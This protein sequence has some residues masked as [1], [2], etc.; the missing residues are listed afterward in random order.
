MT[1]HKE[2][3]LYTVCQQCNTNCG[4]RVKV[5]QGRVVKIEGNPYNPW[6]KTP[7]LAYDTPLTEAAQQEGAL[8]PKGYAGMQTLYDPYRIKKVLKRVGKRGEGAWESIDFH[9]AIQEVVR[10][11][12]L[13]GEGHVQ[14][15]QDIAT[16][17]DAALMAALAKDAQAV[18]AKELSLEDFKQKHAAHLH[19]LI[20]PNHPDLGPKNNQ[21]CYMWGR[22]KGGRAEFAKR[23]FR[24]NLGS[25]NTHGHTTICQGSL[26][27]TCKAMSEQFHE[28]AFTGGEKFYWQADTQHASFI[29]FVGANPMEANY[30]PTLRAG[31]LV[32]QMAAG[33]QRIAVADPRYSKTA[34]KA[35]KWI[36]VQPHGVGALG[37]A[38]IRWIVEHEKYDATY[39]ANCTKGAA[40]H[41]GEPTWTQGA[42]LVKIRADGSPGPLLR[43]S[44]LGIATQERPK[45]QGKQG[46]TWKFDAFVTL[47]QG[48]PLC[49]D[50]NAVDD[51]VHGELFVD[52]FVQG[53]RV[54]SVLQIYKEACMEKSLQEWAEQAGT[55]EAE[56]Q[57]LAQEFTAHGKKAVADIH[58]GVSQHTNGFYN[59]AIWMMVNVLMG[60]CDWKGGMSKATTYDASG[61]KAG[62]PFCISEG[63]K[64]FPWGI[65]CI[66]HG[67]HY[68]KTTL[69]EGYPAKRVW[70]PFASDIYQEV[71]PS[72]ADGYPYPIKALFLYMAAPT[73]SLPAGHELIKILQDVSAIPL[74]VAS[75]IT[76]GESS[77]Y[78][79]YIFPDVTYLER[80]EF[81]GSHPSQVCKVAPVRQPVVA[82]LTD[83]VTVYGVPMSLTWETTLLAMAER[84][85]LSG[86]GAHAF[87]E[88]TPLYRQEDFYLRMVANIAHGEKADGTQ[89][90]P[91]ASDADIQSF[92]A[93]RAHLPSTIFDAQRWQHVVGAELWPHVVTVLSRGGRFQE[94]EDAYTGEYL[95]NAYGKMISIYFDTLAR[96]IHSMTGQA[97]VPYGRVMESPVDCLGRALPDV[98]AGYDLTLI[99][100]KTITQCKS[101]T[102]GNTWLRALEPENHV[103]LSASDA[104]RLGIQD[105]DAVHILSASNPKGLWHICARHTKPMVGKA[106]ILQGLRPGVVA[107]SLG[108]GHWANGAGDV[109]IDGQCVEGD[110]RR[111]SG[112]HANAAMRV[113]PVLQNT[114]LQDVVGGSVVFYQTA[115][116]VVKV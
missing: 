75:D 64:L 6:T 5:Q 13:F 108:Y 8:C 83:T 65:S 44:D 31:K 85:Q 23:F 88:N 3:Q 114:A 70:F 17:R 109:Y 53:H 60:N 41:D 87:G 62:G 100:Y 106:K 2:E 37:M 112:I 73:Y 16:L 79:D 68:E 66:R 38:M 63:K 33:K 29:L 18:A 48:K 14:G 26:Y 20:D 78:A 1:R 67:V 54:K 90:V 103:E 74:L 47:Y 32:Q 7:H 40:L 72:A 58:R 94:Y 77:M 21:I 11:G 93:A 51:V 98:A 92:V 111:A 56:I 89:K 55:T 105:G 107:F 25:V 49:F 39:L 35:W 9:Q 42:W 115:V 61:Q 43:A 46:D 22:Q 71:L 30:G 19:H 91:P 69:F 59:V 76:I 101:R 50:P 95:S 15:L 84:L 27:F 81:S 12:N 24:D 45:S 36:A 102:A 110:M 57:T 96:S 104:A 99:T 80:W 97:Y 113:D 82:P 28:G 34:A 86:F 4:I 10:G 52:T 116:K